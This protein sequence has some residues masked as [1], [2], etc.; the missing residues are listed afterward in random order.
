MKPKKKP[1][2]S[3]LKPKRGYQKHNLT[4]VIKAVKSKGLSALDQRSTI[5]KAA[6]K[7]RRELFTD[8]GGE[9]SLSIQQKTLIED[10]IKRV[11]ILQSI[12]AW[13]F[14]QESLIDRRHRALWPIVP[15]RATIADGLIR[16]L[17]ELGL[18]KVAKNVPSIQS[19]IDQAGSVQ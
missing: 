17:R 14:Q 9:E 15:Q 13:L 11:V 5:A 12:D 18:A 2:K 4:P 19:Y 7:L 8:L 16:C 10:A 1:T 3:A 6:G